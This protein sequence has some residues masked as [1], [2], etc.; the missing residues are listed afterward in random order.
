VCLTDNGQL[1][2]IPTSYILPSLPEKAEF[3]P[4][5]VLQLLIW[6]WMIPAAELNKR[7]IKN[8]TLK[9]DRDY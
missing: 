1:I 4:F 8:S 5:C 2:F 7:S 3:L 9:W 6:A